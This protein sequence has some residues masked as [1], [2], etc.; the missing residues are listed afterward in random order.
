[1]VSFENRIGPCVYIAVYDNLSKCILDTLQFAHVKTG[2][3]SV[4]VNKCSK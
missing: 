4:T 1:M 2:Q 3:T